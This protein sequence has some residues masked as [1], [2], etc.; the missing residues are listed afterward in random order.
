M[1]YK[2]PSDAFIDSFRK[3][4]EISYERNN[5]GHDIS[6]RRLSLCKNAMTNVQKKANTITKKLIDKSSELIFKPGDVVLVPLDDVNCTKVDGG[7]I[8]GVVV[9]IDKKKS[10]C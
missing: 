5:I 10:I 8:C 4:V 9:T 2:Y 3:L 6:P 1:Y 7:N